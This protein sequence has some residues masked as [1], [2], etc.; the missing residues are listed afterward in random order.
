[1][2]TKLYLDTTNPKLQF[3][4]LYQQSIFVPIIFSVIFHTIIYTLFCNIGSYVFFGKILSNEVNKR[5]VFALL[6][7][8]FYGYFAR[9]FHVKD[10]YNAYN[11]DMTKTR[12]HL[13][14]LYISWLF[15]S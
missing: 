6:P 11:G 7:I 5:L 3:R 2:F 10:I 4:Q 15:I 13:D 14:K 9:F 12:N 1:M 8:M